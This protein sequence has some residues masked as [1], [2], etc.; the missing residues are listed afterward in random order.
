M[1]KNISRASS[2]IYILI[3]FA[4]CTGGE[5]DPRPG[6]GDMS[7]QVEHSE[8]TETSVRMNITVDFDWTTE[9]QRSIEDVMV[10][11]YDTEGNVMAA[12]NL[13]TFTTPSEDVE[14]ELQMSDRPSYIVVDHPELRKHGFREIRYWDEER[15]YYD[16]GTH[17]DLPF[18]YPRSNESGTCG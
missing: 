17:A 10:C 13:G 18:E 7:V 12:E 14:T 6:S 2:L 3:L 8:I 11:A 4:G 1:M 15:D 9:D 5:V 16:I